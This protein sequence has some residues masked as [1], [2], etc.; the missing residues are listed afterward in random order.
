MGLL[1]VSKTDLQEDQE[2]DLDALLHHL[3]TGPNVCL[4]P[5]EVVSLV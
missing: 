4:V 1:V 5:K 3:T 2:W